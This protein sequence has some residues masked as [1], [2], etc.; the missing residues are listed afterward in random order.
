MMDLRSLAVRMSPLVYSSILTIVE[1]RL[2]SPVW[3]SKKISEVVESR[4]WSDYNKVV[5]IILDRE[6]LVAY[7]GSTIRSIS[8]RLSEHIKIDNRINW[9]RVMIVPLKNGLVDAELREYE[10]LIGRR[11]RPYDNSKLPN[12]SY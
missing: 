4:M 5:Y 7:V 3:E 9:E 12:L 8:E 11:L 1:A 10:G 6:N 2:D